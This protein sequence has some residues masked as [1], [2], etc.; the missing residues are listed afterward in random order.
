MTMPI[1]TG[2]RPFAPFGMACSELPI[3]TGTIGTPARRA[4]N[5]APSNRSVIT[6]PL[7]RV[8]SG[9]MTSASP[10]RMASS[11]SRRASRSAVPRWTGKP[12]RAVSAHAHHGFFQRLSLPM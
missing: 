11:P 9:K 12:P 2:R 6:G 7:R 10:E 8:P 1:F 5:A 3:P 4:M